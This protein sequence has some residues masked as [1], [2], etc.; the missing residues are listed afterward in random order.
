M[1]ET[2]LEAKLGFDRVRKAISDRCSTEY[3]ASRVAGEE[4]VSDPEEISRRLLLTDEMRL[5]LMFEESFPTNGYIDCLPFLKPLEKEG[6]NID[7]L[8][9]GK[10]KTMLETIRKVTHFFHEIKDGIYPNLKRM[11]AP[12][13]YFSEV[14]RRIDNILDKFGEVKDTASN[15]L[16]SIRKSLRDKEANISKRANAILKKAQEEGIVDSDMGISIRDGKYLI[17]ISTSNKRSL[18]GFVYDESASG[19]TT[20]V[21][22]A[23]I[24]ELENEINELR[25]AETREISKILYE[26]SEFLR[27]YVPD[28]INGAT[29][30]G[31]LDFL[32]AKAQT[33]IDYI[34]GMP[35]ISEKGEMFLRKARH[36]ILEK[37]LKKEKK[38]IVP[39]SLALSPAK[40]ILLISG[41]NA[42]GK[43]VCLKTTGLLQYMFQ[44]GMLIPTSETS[45]LPVFD[46][47]MV[48]IGDDQSIDNDLSTYSSFL[49]DMKDML[50]K[51]D[52]KTLVLIDEFGSGTE[53]TAGGAIAEAILSELDKRGTYGVITTHYTNLK[54][55]ASGASTGVMNGAMQFDAKNIAPLFQLEMGLPGNS[56][57]FE[58]ARKLGLPET[59]VK[60]AENRAGEEFVGIE[61]N[62]RKIVRNRRAIDEKLTR[63]RQT[64]KALENITEKYEQELTAIKK[65]KNEIIDEAKREAQEIVK[66]ANRQVEKTI[67]DIKEA[68][69]EKTQTKTARKEL[70]DFMSAL[71]EHK[72]SEQKERDEY[73][74]KKLSQIAKRRERNKE[75]RGIRNEEQQIEI[76]RG[77][78]LKV[79]EKVR[80]KDNGMVGEIAVVSNKAATIIIGNISSKLPLDRI[81][82]ISSNEFKAAAKEIV[83]PAVQKVDESI[84]RRKLNFKTELDIRGERLSDALDIVTHYIDDA[85]ML[86]MGSVRIIH[87]KG[88]GVLRDEIQKYLRTVPGVSSA[89]D[90]QIQLGG[91]GVTVVTFD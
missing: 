8:S 43:S 49:E 75:R 58:L 89:K 78:P 5:I 27:P 15:E 12:I 36:P 16:Y 74:D 67:R 64:D 87:G 2:R 1:T 19:K 88:T 17:P 18:Q 23:E 79:G 10:L 72:S 91:S 9:L 20:F 52:G 32:M 59:I 57:A 22:P 62:L 70:Q 4:F 69:A 24:I 11:A 44:W 39:L 41:P 82:R 63:I 28:L 6:F 30:L 61:R 45:E 68:Q 26:F 46:R 31:E 56:F 48:S 29:F 85:I 47:I 55:Y 7:L 37:A 21:E 3:A 71:Q 42:G 73:I 13:L 84:T 60:D 76:F 50:A 40:H 66:G 86:N 51:A 53:P 77:G 35:L 34:A 25:F 54:L 38:T 65:Q 14:Q 80:I 83:R 81:E 90:E 33:A